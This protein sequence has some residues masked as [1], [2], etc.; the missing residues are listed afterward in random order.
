MGRRRRRRG[1]PYTGLVLLDK[2]QGITSFKAV[3]RVRRALGAD[4]AGHTGTLDPMAT[5][6]LPICLG[7][8]TRLAQFVSDADKAYTATVRLGQGTD[9]LDA[10]GEVVATDEPAAVEAVDGAAFAAALASFRGPIEQRPPAFSAIKVDGERLYAKARRGE[11]VEV[12]VR[13]VVIHRLE[14]I[15][16]APPEFTIAVTC[17]KGTYIRSLA[18]DIAAALGLH[19]H[20]VALR[21]TAV[22]HLDVVDAVPLDALEGDPQAALARRLSPADAVAHLP[23]VRPSAALVEH[24]S[25]GRRRPLPDA[26]QGRCRVLDGDGRLVAIVDVPATGPVEIVRGLPRPESVAPNARDEQKA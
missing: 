22:A 20:L 26:P 1:Q 19:G 2:P 18:A 3:D 6:L 5:G 15:D 21:R 4:K 17:S 12:P 10:E 25:H 9:S 14:L 7:H 13:A 23:A 16:A 11:D 24:L 8:T